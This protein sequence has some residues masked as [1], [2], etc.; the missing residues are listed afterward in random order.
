MNLKRIQPAADRVLVQWLDDL[1]YWHNS[2]IALVQKDETTIDAGEA[3][4]DRADYRRKI[5]RAEVLACGPG[6]RD[7]DGFRNPMQ[8]KPGDVVHVT[9]WNDC[10]EL[11]KGFAIVREG[12]ISLLVHAVN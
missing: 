2:T 10:E 7:E 6:A 4:A 5:I 3:D 8:V 11:P 12:D 9:A 1:E